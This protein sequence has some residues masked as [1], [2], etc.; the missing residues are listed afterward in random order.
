MPVTPLGSKDQVNSLKSHAALREATRYPRYHCYARCPR[1]HSRLSLS[2][3]GHGVAKLVA[4]PSQIF[5]LHVSSHF[6]S[7]VSFRAVRRTLLEP[8]VFLS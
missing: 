6:Q 2:R 1:Y 3:K 4:H 7:S 5:L 8:S